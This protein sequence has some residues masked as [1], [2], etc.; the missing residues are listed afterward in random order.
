MFDFTIF[1]EL[2]YS[3]DVSF[4]VLK[5]EINGEVSTPDRS[6]SN[7]AVEKDVRIRL[8]FVSSEKDITMWIIISIASGATIILLLICVLCKCGFFKR[9]GTDAQTGESEMTDYKSGDQF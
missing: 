1:S 2:L 7:G 5:I 8:N 4:E 6:K 9:G 3:V